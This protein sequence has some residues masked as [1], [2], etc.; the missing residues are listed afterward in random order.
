MPNR[1]SKFTDNNLKLF[2]VNL[3]N[4][5][6]ECTKRFG[7]SDVEAVYRELFL[8][9]QFA[10]ESPQGSLSHLPRGEKDKVYIA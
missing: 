8:S 5:Y 10:V 9:T 4:H 1:S 6:K 3:L 7:S 2:Y